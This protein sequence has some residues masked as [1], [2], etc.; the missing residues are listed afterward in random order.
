MGGPLAVVDGAKLKC[1]KGVGESRLIALSISTVPIEGH[2]V[3]TT[4][5][6]K[7]ANIPPFEHC[8]KLRGPCVPDIPKPWQNNIFSG[9]VASAGLVDV[10][11]SDATLKCAV[12]GTLTITDPNQSTVPV[13]VAQAMMSQDVDAQRELD[14]L[15]EELAREMVKAGLDACGVV[16]PTPFCDGSSAIMSLQD[17]AYLDAALS[18]L[19]MIPY[20]GD[21]FG[22]SAKGARLV[23]KLQRLGK[24]VAELRRSLGAT[25]AVRN[26][27]LERAAGRS[28]EAVERYGRAIPPGRRMPR[29]HGEW[30][31]TRGNSGW[32]SDKPEVNEITN[33]QPVPYR[34]G[35]PDY[36][37]W[38]RGEVK[39][40]MTGKNGVDRARADEVF[41]KQRGWTKPNGEPDTRQAAKYRQQNELVW[42]HVE[43]GRTMQLV[44][45]PLNDI[46][47]SGGASIVRARGR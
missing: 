10:L 1:T 20:V 36:S 32:K 29:R 30:D 35:Y 18:A 8:K 3:A 41:A 46:P 14:E 39:I 38:S 47:H 17:G 45:K 33:G 2:T 9:V 31:G 26:A 25:R 40:D 16:E 19:S 12:T 21:L 5:D 7:P 43:D 42:H 4:E 23:R 22:K 11:A 6:Y 28:L 44:P 34:N 24:R 37:R 13:G 15:E 27:A